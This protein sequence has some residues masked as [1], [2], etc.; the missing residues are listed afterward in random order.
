MLEA[1]AMAESAV[2]QTVRGETGTLKMGF[3]ASASLTIVPRLAHAIHNSWPGLDVQLNEMTTAVQLEALAHRDLDVGLGR[4]VGTNPDLLTRPLVRERLYAA[5]HDSHWLAAYKSIPLARLAN[6]R[7]VGF[8]RE[9]VS[10]LYDHIAR[11]CEHAGFRLEIAEEAVQF[12]TILGL[13][14]GN[15]GVAIVPEPLRALQLPGL[16]F[17]ALEDEAAMS[18]VSLIYRRDQ[19]ESPTLHRFLDIASS[20]FPPLVLES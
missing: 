14:A 11:L 7:F 18:L 8:S 5:V 13:V 2:S 6:E 17:I 10:L 9:R 4:E 20:I 15:A 1:L 3:V 19:A 12:M 16:R